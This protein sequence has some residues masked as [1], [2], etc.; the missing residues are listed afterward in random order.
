MIAARNGRQE[1]YT[2]WCFGGGNC[3]PDFHQ[4]VAADPGMDLVRAVL[5]LI[6]IPQEG[7]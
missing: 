7:S 6:R 3:S 5:A 1:V 4:S 2:D